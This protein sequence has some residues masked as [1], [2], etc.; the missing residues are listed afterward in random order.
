MNEENA[1]APTP[2]VEVRKINPLSY[3]KRPEL[4]ARICELEEK[5]KN[6]ELEEQ[7]K[8]LDQCLKASVERTAFVVAQND[9]IKAHYE[10]LDDALHA[11]EQRRADLHTAL[12]TKNYFARLWLALCGR[13]Q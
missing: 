9:A 1:I 11:E 7:V 8:Y 10:E 13:Y 6:P 3:L 2:E 5:L 12:R 4:E